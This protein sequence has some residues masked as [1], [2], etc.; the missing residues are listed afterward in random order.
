M[1]AVRCWQVVQFELRFGAFQRHAYH[2]R[3][4]LV[5]RLID[6]VVEAHYPELLPLEGEA[7][8]AGLLSA[9]VERSARLTARWMAAGFVHG[10]LNTDN[11]NITGES[12]DYGPY[13]FLPHADGGFTAAYFDQSGLYSFG[14][15]PE[16]V[17]WSLKQLA[18]VLAYAGGDGE[19]FAEAL[20]AFGPAYERA[21]AQAVIARLGLKGKDDAADAALAD[22]AFR[23]LAEA[24][25][26][27]RWEPFF[28]DW[29]G[30]L[31]SERRALGGRRRALY[32]GAAAQAFRVLLKDYEP[33][34]PGRL[35][36]AYF[37]APEPEELLYDEIEAL[38]APIAEHDDWTAFNA[39]LERIAEARAAWGLAG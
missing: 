27:V 24:S 26:A 21:L 22:A 38:W 16:A 35:T 31:A 7:R 28:F 36:R 5:T 25:P 6:H 9:V 19:A 30:G 15:Q 32:G 12:F 4:D 1:N 3:P 11:M 33:R 29:F 37:Q 8:A 2:Q 18:G 23:A 17:F 14:R 13:R 34:T 10:V 20:R 39:K